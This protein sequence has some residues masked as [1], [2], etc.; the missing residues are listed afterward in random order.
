MRADGP[1]QTLGDDPLDQRGRQVAGDAD[2]DEPCDGRRGVVG[3]QGG[4]DQVAGHGG[5]HGHLRG[6]LVPDLADKDDIRILAKDGPE[7]AR[8]GQT[9]VD[10]DLGLVDT[11]DVG[12][13]RDFDWSVTRRAIFSP[14]RR[15]SEDTRR[16]TS[17]CSI[18]TRMAPSCG[19]RRSAISILARTLKRETIDA[20]TAFGKCMVS[21]RR[22]STRSRTIVSFLVGSTWMSLTRERTASVMSILQSRTTGACRV[23]SSRLWISDSVGW[24]SAASTSSRSS[25]NSSVLSPTIRSTAAATSCFR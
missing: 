20:C 18:F 25:L 10:V 6:F 16:S 9:R 7:G 17:R 23:A 22:P 19:T 11:L 15:G 14:C 1:D 13:D 21:R 12:L 5:P 3:V 24:D 4:E 8:K 2:V